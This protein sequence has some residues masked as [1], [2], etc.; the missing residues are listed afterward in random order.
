MLLDDRRSLLLL[1]DPQTRLL[2]ALPPARAKALLPRWLLLVKAAEILGIPALVTRQ[3]PQGL[4]PLADPL[5]KALPPAVVC[6]DK[7]TFSCVAD[8]AIARLLEIERDQVVVAGIETH[9]CVLQTA[10]DL[11]AQGARPAVVADAC[12]SRHPE[13]H[14]LALTRLAQSGVALL[15]AESVVFEWMRDA[16][17]PRFR[18]LAPL[19]KALPAGDP[20]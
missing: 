7:T 17:H 2:G 18:E 11:V 15:T 16:A 13:S 8:P 5:L 6:R 14:A 20:A 19:I 4:G 1:V 3:Y 10:L 12:G 9:V